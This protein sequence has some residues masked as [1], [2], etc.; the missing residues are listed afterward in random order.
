MR[1]EGCASEHRLAGGCAAGMAVATLGTWLRF[2]LERTPRLDTH[3]RPFVLGCAVSGLGL[4]LAGVCALRLAP[5]AGR[6]SWRALWAWTLAVQGAAVGALAL[7]SS[8]VFGNLAFGALARAGLSPYAHAPPALGSSPFVAPLSSRW[9]NDPS[10]YG[11]LFHPIAAAAVWLGEQTPSPFWGSFFLYKAL[12]LGALLGGLWLAARHLRATRGGEA[13]EIF[14]LLAF[15][16][17][18]AWEIPAQ[19]HNDGLL[20]LATVAFLVAAASA[21]PVLAVAAL[22]AGVAVKYVLGPLL[23][24]YALLVARRS[25]LRAVGL[26]LLALA[27]LVAAFLPERDAVTLR[28]VLPMLGRETTRHAHSLTDLA[29]LALEALGRPEASARAYRLLSALSSAACAGLLLRAAW[30]ARTLAE[31]A[32]GYLLFLF[33]LYLTAPWFQPW[34]PCWAMPLLVVEPSPRWRRFVALF[35]V[36]TVVQWALPLDPVSTVAADLWAAARLW[37]LHRGEDRPQAPAPGA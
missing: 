23:G 8:D 28:S 14:A 36:V 21:R 4:A 18:L 15:S 10:P 13:P 25:L 5:R 16:P 33:G 3:T 31:V 19:G 1:H 17:L 22:A 37:Q 35:G 26:G 7:T 27:V 12:L 32:R 20:F 30:R 2:A 9:V 11:P 34:Y 6:L 29:C 24:L